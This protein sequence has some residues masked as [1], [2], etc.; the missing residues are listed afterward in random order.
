MYSGCHSL[1]PKNILHY[2][3]FTE[4]TVCHTNYTNGTEETIH[5]ALVVWWTTVPLYMLWKCLKLQRYLSG[6]ISSIDRIWKLTFKVDPKLCLLWWLDEELYAP[7]TYTAILRVL[8][9][10]RRL[11]ARK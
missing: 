4:L 8:F 9:I 3:L 1:L 6:V 11:I 5:F 10:A 2:S 7:Y